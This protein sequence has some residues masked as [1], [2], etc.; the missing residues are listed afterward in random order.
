MVDT[1][2]ILKLLFF[3]HLDTDKSLN[4]K[5]CNLSVRPQSKFYIDIYIR[6]WWG[7]S[8]KGRDWDNENA[9]VFF[10]FMRSLIC[11]RD[12]FLVHY[13]KDL[14]IQLSFSI[15]VILIRH[16]WVNRT[17]YSFCFACLY[18]ILDELDL[19][20][21]MMLQCQSARVLTIL[22]RMGCLFLLGR[23]DLLNE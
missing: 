23:K 7:G 18:K 13:F 10:V 3:L 12:W 8:V 2:V 14:S 21:H 9:Y 19:L 16:C 20:V 15:W 4:S 1:D 17:M 11:S 6:D 22:E 5:T